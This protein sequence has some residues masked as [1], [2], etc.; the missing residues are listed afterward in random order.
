[1]QQFEYGSGIARVTTQTKYPF[2]G[3]SNNAALFYM[4]GSLLNGLGGNQ[5]WL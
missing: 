1:M 5:L 2:R 4:T 3:V